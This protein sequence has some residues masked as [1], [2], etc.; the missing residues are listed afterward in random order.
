MTEKESFDQWC[1]VEIFGHQR[2]AGKVSEQ[3]IGGC[4][5]V[6]LDVPAV[7]DRRPFTKLWGEKAIYCITPVDEETAMITAGQLQQA[8]MDTWSVREAAK[9]LP[10]PESQLF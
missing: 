4:H 9:T 3:V 7:N 10:D 5:F 2:F 8:P 1:I 6:R